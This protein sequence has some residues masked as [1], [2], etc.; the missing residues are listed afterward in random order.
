[1]RMSFIQMSFSGAIL[2]LVIAVV[3]CFAMNKL[4]KNIFLVFWGIVLVRLLIP[5]SIPSTFSVYSLFTV[6]EAVNSAITESPIAGLLPVSE[7]GRIV[8]INIAPVPLAE[9]TNLSILNVVYV[10]GCVLLGVAFLLAYVACYLKVK[11]ARPV[12]NEFISFWMQ[13]HKI[14]RMIHICEC[15]GISSPLTYGVMRP[16]ILLPSSF[17]RRDY[18]QL[19]Y[20]L[21]HELIHI[22]RF[23][24][25]TKMLLVIVLCIHW[26]NPAVW[27]MYFLFNRDLELSCDEAVVRKNGFQS[28]KDYALT[29]I[30][31]EEERNS[32]F[33]LCS[34]FSRNVS[35]ERITAIMKTK[36]L[37]LISY[38]AALLLVFSLCT[39]FMTSAHALETDGTFQV[40]KPVISG[41]NQSGEDA[42]ITVEDDSPLQSEPSKPV[43]Q[44]WAWPTLSTNIS[45]NFGMLSRPTGEVFVDHINISCEEDD[46]VFSA[47]TGTVIDAGFDAEYGN[48]IIIAGENNVK[49]VYGHLK[50]M[51]VTENDYVEAGERIGSAGS[52]GTA[53]SYCLSFAVFVND[54]A[55]DPMGYYE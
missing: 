54:E 35:E 2:I 5:F 13:K 51:L 42:T 6:N 46:A 4:P 20:I 26:F 44:K 31:L 28:R 27:L 50:T 17:D 9:T 29:L 16:I 47:I 53:T 14:R 21:Q 52:S 49:T 40:D 12:S 11:A 24:F 10:A 36:R 43:Q 1:M 7:V 33:L 39:G 48:Y 30:T 15:D 34:G 45:T 25:I 41:H 55:V 22:C 38:L 32:A 19:N 23:D 8:E 3:R 18:K 37:S